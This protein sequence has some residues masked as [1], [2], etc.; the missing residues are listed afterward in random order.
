MFQFIDTKKIAHVSLRMV[1]I[2]LSNGLCC[3][4]PLAFAQFAI[5]LI[6]NEEYGLGYRLGTLSLRLLDKINAQRYTSAV[7]ALVGT[8]VS[9]V[10]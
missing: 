1:Q 4:S 6:K 7:V 8:L 5:I 3:M 9:W 2:T 10:A